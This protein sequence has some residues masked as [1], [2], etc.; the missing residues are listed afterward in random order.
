MSRDTPKRERWRWT[1]L[2]VLIWAA[3]AGFAVFVADLTLY[4]IVQGRRRQTEGRRLEAHNDGRNL[5]LAAINYE[6]LNYVLPP[7]LYGDTARSVAEDRSPPVAWMTALLPY[8]DQAAVHRQIDFDRPF[9]HPPNIAAFAT[10]LRLYRSP[11]VRKPPAVAGLAPAHWAGNQ[12][13]I[14]APHTSAGLP[15]GAGQT[16]LIGEVSAA[17]G[18]PA[19]WGDPTNLRT[20]AGPLNSPTGFGGNGPDGEVIVVTADGR[21]RFISEN[22]DPAVFAALGTPDGGETV[23]PGDW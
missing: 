20:S 6:Q 15:D 1:P 4:E 22:I 23:G 12:L 13:V 14:G 8:V 10:D 18:K 17:T 16:L 3:V 9:D 21:A 5:G 2:R 19:A 7:F 11:H